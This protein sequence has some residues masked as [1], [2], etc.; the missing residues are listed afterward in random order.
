MIDGI[1][2]RPIYLYQKDIIGVY[3]V[4]QIYCHIQIYEHSLVYDVSVLNGDFPLL[5][6]CAFEGIPHP[7][8]HPGV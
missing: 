6:M 5:W 7:I 1:P 2:S 3:K 8:P 4:T